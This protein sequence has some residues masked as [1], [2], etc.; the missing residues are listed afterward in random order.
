M[1]DK[2]SNKKKRIKRR[3]EQSKSKAEKII[4]SKED[5]NKILK[6]AMSKA[7]RLDDGPIKEFIS[8][9]FLLIG[10]VKD[11]IIKEYREIPIGSV[12]SILGAIIYFVSP[13][14]AIPDFIPFIG[15][16]DDAFVIS[17]ILKQVHKDLQKYKIWKENK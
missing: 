15:Y 14:D 1:E 17:L 6:E 4:K 8:D 3:Y 2:N 10:L 9:L 5:V 13:I 12:V 7:D 11:W 16:V